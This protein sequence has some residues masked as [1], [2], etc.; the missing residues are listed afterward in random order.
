LSTERGEAH[1][2]CHQVLGVQLSQKGMD[3]ELLDAGCGAF[4]AIGIPVPEP[5]AEVCVRRLLRLGRWVE[6][7]AGQV[8]GAVFPQA[9]A[10]QAATG[11]LEV[12]RQPALHRPH[13]G[14]HHRADLR[15]FLAIQGALGQQQAEAADVAG[16]IKGERGLLGLQECLG[17]GRRQEAGL[18]SE[19]AS[20]LEA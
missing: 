5:G 20:Q 9:D 10:G 2:F 3:T 7:V 14:H 17:Q 11:Q 13:L 12:V 8:G 16:Q 6:H 19:G 1:P 4:D 18:G 15:A